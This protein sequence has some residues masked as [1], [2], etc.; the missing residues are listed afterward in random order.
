ME[1]IDEIDSLENPSAWG[2]NLARR[3]V[4]R[5]GLAMLRNKKTPDQVVD[6]L[7]EELMSPI[8]LH[9]LNDEDIATIVQ[10]GFLERDGQFL[11]ADAGSMGERALEFTGALAAELYDLLGQGAKQVKEDSGS[12]VVPLFLRNADATKPAKTTIDPS[13]IDTD[14]EREEL[15]KKI[16]TQPLK[17]ERAVPED[18]LEEL[19]VKILDGRTMG[20]GSYADVYLAS[21]KGR[22][23]ILKI[24]DDSDVEMVNKVKKLRETAPPEVSRHLPVIY[25]SIPAGNQFLTLMERL[26]PYSDELRVRLFNPMTYHP[27]TDT[28]QPEEPHFLSK[29]INE[30]LL[31]AEFVRT[32][33]EGWVDNELPLAYRQIFKATLAKPADKERYKSIRDNIIV[34]I[35]RVVYG[36]TITGPTVDSLHDIFLNMKKPIIKNIVNE[37]GNEYKGM[38]ELL[39]K[40][41]WGLRNFISDPSD[42]PYSA[43]ER[44]DSPTQKDPAAE[45]LMDALYW[46]RQ[47]GIAWNDL[48]ENNLMQRAD[49][50]LVLIDF[51]LYRSV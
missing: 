35:V 10:D 22:D 27:N 13:L 38:A 15:E 18:I 34:P 51:D 6:H 23:A 14:L 7:V 25:F 45:S 48:K 19:G 36:A 44:K 28:N 50:T 17:E 40:N 43:N 8:D 31:D 32:A 3:M 20:E 26:Q 42:L 41:I 11:V 2:K 24:S 46:L 47:R 29:K 1:D 9:T 39:V 49:G 12:K 33:V 16:H 37:I 21:Y 5:Y 4:N 30:R